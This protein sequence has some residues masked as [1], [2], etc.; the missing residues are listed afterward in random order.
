MEI[1]QIADHVSTFS[2]NSQSCLMH[3]KDVSLQT[4]SFSVYCCYICFAEMRRF[5]S[6][7]L[8]ALCRNDVS[9]YVSVTNILQKCYYSA[10]FVNVCSKRFAEMRFH[11]P[12]LL[13]VLRITDGR[14]WVYVVFN[15][16]LF[17]NTCGNYIILSDKAN[18]NQTQNYQL[19]SPSENRTPN[20]IM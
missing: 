6:F 13:R 18:N 14:L 15:N 9:M 11:Y 2:Y 7:L 8:Q 20:I 19:H 10:L 12:L 5:S 4:R 16:H 1:V 3:F 17:S